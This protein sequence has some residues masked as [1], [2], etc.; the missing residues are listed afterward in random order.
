MRVAVHAGRWRRAAIDNQHTAAG[1][2]ALKSAIR[3]GLRS[4]AAA[5]GLRQCH[6]DQ[7]AV[8]FP[9]AIE[10]RQATVAMAHNTKR[11]R[12]PLDRA[13]QRCRR[14]RL[15]RLQQGANFG[16]VLQRGKLCGG[17][18]FGMAAIGQHLAD[19]LLRQEPQGARQEAGMLRQRHGRRDQALQR[20]QRPRV[21][22]LGG[23]CG[24]QA[25][26]IR[27]QPRHQPLAECVISG[28]GKEI[29]V[30][31]P[32]GDPCASDI[33]PMRDRLARAEH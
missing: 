30:T 7:T 32:G 13:G 26:C 24:G 21:Q 1:L 11:R 25:T 18:A 31:Q 20:R 23:K 29:V 6:L 2:Q 17:T 5:P 12:H 33:R 16:K 27:H 15:R 28:G 4:P 22:L 10:Q 19:D 3:Q 14:L 8:L 9:A